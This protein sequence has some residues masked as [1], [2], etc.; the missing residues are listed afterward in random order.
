VGWRFDLLPCAFLAAAAA[1]YLAGVRR[2]RKWYPHRAPHA[3]RSLS[4]L[5][6]LLAIA[7]ALESPLDAYADRSFSLHM[8]QHAVLMML[9][10]PALVLGEPLELLLATAPRALARAVVV[11]LRSWPARTARHPVFAWCAFCAVLWGTHYS[12]LY[13]LALENESVHQ[14]EHALYLAAALVFWQFALSNFVVPWAPRPLTHPLR[15]AY[16]TSFM[17]V[18]AFLGLSL[19]ASR[20][21]L[22]PHYLHV[23][24]ASAASALDDQRAGG[25]LMWLAGSFVMLVAMVAVMAQW[26]RES[27]RQTLR[28]EGSGCAASEA[29]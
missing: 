12:P 6:G 17:P 4:F 11:A 8:A 1:L 3:W 20:R 5:V 28:S 18:S 25:E 19:S 23:A 22:Y 29:G 26:A 16:L 27:E 13:E 10:A 2:R 21:V 14:A 9:A 7:L 24:G 15:V